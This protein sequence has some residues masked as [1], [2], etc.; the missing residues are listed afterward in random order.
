MRPFL[1][2]N[3][4]QYQKPEPES[5][6]EEPITPVVQEQIKGKVLP[7]GK[8]EPLQDKDKALFKMSKNILFDKIDNIDSGSEIGDA[9]FLKN[10]IKKEEIEA[11]MFEN[12]APKRKKNKVKAK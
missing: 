2:Y 5:L 9:N 8:E 7:K 4:S 11:K 1:D 12:P 3:F 10:D 6:N